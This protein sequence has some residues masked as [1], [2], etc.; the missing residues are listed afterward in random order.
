[1]RQCSSKRTSSP[2]LEYT[3]GEEISTKCVKGLLKRR[4]G[5]V[6]H[7]LNNGSDLSDENVQERRS[8]REGNASLARVTALF[9]LVSS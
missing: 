7:K 6:A 8:R 4:K 2:N 9:S 3:E 1:M 5:R